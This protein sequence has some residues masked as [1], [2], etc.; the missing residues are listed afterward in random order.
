MDEEKILIEPSK[1]AECITLTLIREGFATF[2][3]AEEIRQLVK[4][5][6]IMLKVR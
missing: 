5:D 2:E 3:F 1:T 6:L 4:R